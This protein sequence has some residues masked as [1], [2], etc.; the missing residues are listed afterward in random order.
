MKEKLDLG[1][2]GLNAGGKWPSMFDEIRHQ[3]SS[4]R[5]WLLHIYKGQTELMVT[6]GRL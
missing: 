4:L 3:R 1:R 5:E 2:T 6:L